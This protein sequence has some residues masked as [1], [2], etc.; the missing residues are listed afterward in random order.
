MAVELKRELYIVVAKQ[1]LHGLRIRFGCEP[2]TTPDYG[3]DCEIRTDADH[4][5]LVDRGRP[6]AMTKCQP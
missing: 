3:E 2:G 1:S 6:D 5:L 4:H